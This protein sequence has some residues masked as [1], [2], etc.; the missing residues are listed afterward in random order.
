MAIAFDAVGTWSSGSS[1]FSLSHTCTGSDRFLAVVIVGD[2][3]SGADDITGVTYNS[4]AM[5]LADKVVDTAIARF[6]YLYT[7]IAPATGANNIVVTASGGHFLG[8]VS[9]SYTGVSQTGQPEVVTKVYEDAAADVDHILSLSITP[10]TANSWVIVGAGGYAG[11]P[12]PQASTGTT[13]RAA[14]TSFG[15]IGILDSNA[16]LPASSQSLA[17]TYGAGFGSDMGSI[18]IAIAPSGGGGGL[19]P[20]PAAGALSLTGLG[21][22]L[23]FAINMPDEV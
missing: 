20:S 18:L 4:V 14:D 3:G 22:R 1:P 11:G 16:A 5:T 17:W 7:L 2:V 15:L 9:A 23:G 10:S 13:L 12:A 21:T 19:T 8:A 6:F